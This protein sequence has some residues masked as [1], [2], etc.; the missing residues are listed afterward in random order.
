MSHEIQEKI[1]RRCPEELECEED[2]AWVRLAHHMAQ[3][4][5]QAPWNFGVHQKIAS[6]PA[7]PLLAYQGIPST[8]DMLIK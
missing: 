6:S 5:A 7:N 2:V 4:W 1:R 3:W 8:K